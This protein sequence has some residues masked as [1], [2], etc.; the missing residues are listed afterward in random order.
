MERP[1]LNVLDRA[2]EA[3]GLAHWTGALDTGA[4]SWADAVSGSA[5]S[6]EMAV[7]LTPFAADGIAFV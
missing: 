7:R 4:P 6:H 5:M 1:Y 3:E 2:G